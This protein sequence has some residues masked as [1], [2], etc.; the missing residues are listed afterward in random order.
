MLSAEDNELL[1]HIG[2]GTPMGTLIR[3]YW[4]PALLSQELPER[5]G[6]PARVQL[7]GERLVAF[8]DTE[9]RVGLLAERCPHRQASLALARNEDGGLRCIYHGWKMDV[10]GRVLDTPCEPATLRVQHLA[11][12]T[13]ERGGVIWAYLG[14]P[15]RV[16]PFPEFLWLKVPPSYAHAFKTLEECNYAQA[17][18]GGIDSAHLAILH[19]LAPWGSLEDGRVAATD[20]DLAPRLEVEPAAYGFRYA[21]I[22][23]ARDGGNLVRV[24]PFILPFWTVVPPGTYLDQSRIVNAWVPRDDTTSWHF[25]FFFDVEKPVDVEWRVQNGG[26]QVDAGFRKARNLDNW[27]LQDREAMKTST[28]SGIE[29]VMTQDHAVNETQGPIL[30]RTHEHL[31]SSDGAVI[32]MR[33]LMLRCARAHLQ[34]EDP[35]GLEASLQYD[36]INS[37]SFVTAPDAAWQQVVPVEPIART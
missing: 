6:A 23:R 30:D 32:A 1:T 21:A 37:A 36:Q 9:E 15:D 11:Y 29:G 20:A 13:R 17:I 18:E 5:D 28:M 3:R 34:G 8:R 19:R 24:T 7:M 16:P 33:H 2:P 10:Q 35:P 12:P 27:Y 22:R 26:H 25:Q 14:P 31:G 4:M